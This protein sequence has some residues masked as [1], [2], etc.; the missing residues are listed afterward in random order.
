MGF[1]EANIWIMAI[2]NYKEFIRLSL[3]KSAFTCKPGYKN[4]VPSFFFF[5]FFFLTYAP[6]LLTIY[7]PQKIQILII[8]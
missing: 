5:F 4:F 6:P 7:N 1:L 2:T 8:K 3:K